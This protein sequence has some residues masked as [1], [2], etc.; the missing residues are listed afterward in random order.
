MAQLDD[1]HKAYVATI[2][3]ENNNV[4][5]N[6]AVLLSS[7]NN[8]LK[9]QKP[10]IFGH[11][12]V[13]DGDATIIYG[14]SNKVNANRVMIMGDS[15]V[16][17]D[18]SWVING[19]ISNVKTTAS[20]Q[21]LWV[22]DYGVSINTNNASEILVADGDLVADYFYGDGS[23]LTNFSKLDK[24]WLMFDNLMTISNF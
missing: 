12:N 17:H 4:S 11:D 9:G 21:I 8:K 5:S 23:Q 14:D 2:G 10:H 20:N 24:Y 19:N 22:S 7:K 1:I 15:T 6:Y 3:G 18:D 16:D 13:V